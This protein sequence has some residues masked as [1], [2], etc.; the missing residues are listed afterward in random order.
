[1]LVARQTFLDRFQFLH[2]FLKVEQVFPNLLECVNHCTDC[3]GLAI[4]G[5]DET[6]YYFEQ[7]ASVR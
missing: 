5:H 7:L 1:M 4:S 6:R 2:L 3:F